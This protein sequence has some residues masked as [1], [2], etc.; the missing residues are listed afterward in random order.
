MQEAWAALRHSLKVHF[1]LD[2]HEMIYCGMALG[3]A[4]ESA[5]VNSLRSDRAPV[6][7]FASFRGF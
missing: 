1:A 4:D 2:E 3:Y 7:E 6:E 5:A